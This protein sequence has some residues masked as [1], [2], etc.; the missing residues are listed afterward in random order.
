MRGKAWYPQF[1][2]T[3]CLPYFFFIKI[4]FSVSAGYP[5]IPLCAVNLPPPFLLFFL[6]FSSFFSSL[7]TFP[8]S[9]LFL[10][11]LLL[12]LPPPPPPPPPLP[13]LPLLLPL[14]SL[15]HPASPLV[16][17]QSERSVVSEDDRSSLSP[18]ET[19]SFSAL[20]RL[21]SA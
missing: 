5:L 11:P 9:P 1:L 8:S 3:C 19:A 7:P 14:S 10:L 6:L 15:I 17:Y 2:L 13:L 20:S 12:L 18:R 4:S 21:H 16:G